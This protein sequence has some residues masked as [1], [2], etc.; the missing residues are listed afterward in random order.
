MKE[1]KIPVWET[2]ILFMYALVMFCTVRYHEPWRDEAQAWLI[3]R[4][5]P[6]EAMFKQMAYE[7]GTPPLAYH[8]S[9]FCQTGLSLYI[10]KFNTF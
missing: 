1:S 5:L 8:S 2:F 6:F 10:N 9:L 3:A 7:E 4:D